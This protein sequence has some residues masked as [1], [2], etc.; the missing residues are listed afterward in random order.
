M[1]Y[2]WVVADSTLNG[3]IV[4]DIELFKNQIDADRRA[5]ELGVAC[6]SAVVR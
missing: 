2:V 5:E 4:G 1:N 6:W 3:T